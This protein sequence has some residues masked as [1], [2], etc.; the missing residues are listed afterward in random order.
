MNRKKK[1]SP[2]QG[3]IIQGGMLVPQGM[4]QPDIVLQ[5]PEIFM[6]DMNAYMQ[7][8][9]AAKGIDFSNRARLYDMYDSASLDLHLSG[10]I[11]K[12]MRGVTKIPIEFRRNGV[13]DDAI[14]NQIKSPWF[15]QLRKDL[16]MSEFWGFTLVQFYLNDEGN[17]R[18]DLINR[19]HYDPIHRKLLKYQ[20]SMDGV[21]ID[22][23]PDMLF[24]GS[25]R[26]LGIYAELLPA[27]LY[28]RGDMS[29]WAQFC[30]IFGMPIREYTYDAGDEEARRRVIADAR[31]QG[32]NAAYIHPK[33]SELKLVEAG[34]KTGSSDLYRTFAEY[35][36][37]KMSIRVLGNT[38]TTDAKSTGTQALGSVHKEE[39][40]E[41]NSDDRDFILDILN[42]DMRPIFAS[43]GFNVE[44]GEFVYAKKDKINPAQQIDIVQKLSSMG[45]PI[46][47][48]YL[49]ETF[50]VAKPDNYNQLKEEKEAAK[51][52]FREQLGMQGNDDGKKKQDKNT[53]K[54]AFKQHLRSF[55]GLAPDK[56]A[57]F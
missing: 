54:T 12:R 24:V 4:R 7:S 21:P 37:S 52:A 56:G 18:Y 47:D 6:F 36:D 49:Y 2:K 14:N 42:Y 43:L 9:K 32:A 55:F 31:R 48:D 38:L 30:N 39:E 53:D 8:V 35:W 13:P 46:D 57:H 27:V 29:D 44:G 15:K 5:M 34:N 10:V 16:V 3:K 11:A 41:M 28:K 25:E 23:F 26:D 33:E 1:N 22:D 19:K 45:L 17:I 51:A 40:D 50:C 20:G